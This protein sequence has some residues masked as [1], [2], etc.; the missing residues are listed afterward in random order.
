MHEKASLIGFKSGEYARRY[1][2]R[3][4]V[5]EWS[6]WGRGYL[7]TSDNILGTL[8]GLVHCTQTIFTENISI[9]F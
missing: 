4:P 5:K 9:T 8:S 2:N 1:S 7:E 3:A 6:H